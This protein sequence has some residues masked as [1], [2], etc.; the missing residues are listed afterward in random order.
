MYDAWWRAQEENRATVLFAP[1]LLG[2]I[3]VKKTDSGN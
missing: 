1:P 3:G 2:V